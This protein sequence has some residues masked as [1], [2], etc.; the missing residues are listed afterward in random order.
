M[1]NIINWKLF[2]ILLAGSVA[3]ALMVLPYALALIPPPVPIIT[4]LLLIGQTIQ[5]LVIYSIAAFFGLLLVKRVGFSMP[6]LEGLLKG[7]KTGPYFKSILGL[8]LGLGVLTAILII[9]SSLPFGSL[10]STFLHAEV[11]IATWKSFLASF[12]GGLAEEVLLRLFIMTLLVWITFKIK[13]T[14]EGK[15]TAIGIWIAII[16]SAIL[17]GLGHLPITSTVTAITPVVVI[18][19]IVLNGI[20]GIIFGW[21]YWK[22]GLESAMIAHFTADIGLHVILPLIATLLI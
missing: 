4:P 6:I 9:L 11:S 17:F 5:S 13:K 8:S 12:E 14:K 10:S 1:K 22:K 7:E 16:L 3:T 2:F 18:R 20:G 15:P 21:L 19:A